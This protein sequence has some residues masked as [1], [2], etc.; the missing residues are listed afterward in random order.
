MAQST[1]YKPAGKNKPFEISLER[2]A[3]V[4]PLQDFPRSEHWRLVTD[5][6]Q[7]NWGITAFIS[8][9]YQGMKAGYD[10]MRDYLNHKSP[11]TVDLIQALQKAAF[12][13][14]ADLQSKIG[15]R[16]GWG[17][18][19]ITK[20]RN[21]EN[22]ISPE[23]LDEL[24]AEAK[25]AHDHQWRLVGVDK[26]RQVAIDSEKEK[27]KRNGL[28]L[29]LG[30]HLAEKAKEQ[31]LQTKDELSQFLTSDKELLFLFAMKIPK[32]E[33]QRLLEK[34]IQQLD[35]E[36]QGLSSD[37]KNEDEKIA[38][39][40][41]FL[42]KLNLNHFFGDGNGRTCM[43]LLNCF[44]IK[45]L[46]CMSIIPTPAHLTAFSTKELVQEI[47]NGMAEFRK[48]SIKEP[49]EFIE[50]FVQKQQDFPEGV[51]GF[52]NEFNAKF[53]KENHIAL[54]QINELFVRIHADKIKAGKNKVNIL[55]ILKD[56]YLDRLIK[57]VEEEKDRKTHK[58]PKLNEEAF[59]A[60]LQYQEISKS[61]SSEIMNELIA[62]YKPG[63][64][65]KLAGS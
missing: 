23:G 50:N 65:N 30:N 32:D 33:A 28:L 61:I 24:V 46:D 43:I 11:L 45:Y 20:T 21:E 22:G 7:Q 6:W 16:L 64:G 38:A 58:K 14:C 5:G 17:Y 25:L 3:Y 18:F 13:P 51:K 10:V 55:E 31:K 36:M 27:E 41:R 15:F 34:D 53:S 1:L 49:R 4:D 37:A 57:F 2:K 40:V 42:R 9:Y 35:K 47:K 63:K 62:V 29:G 48:Y 52:K 19:L 59:L 60:M 56:I 39:I 26:S 54:A 12:G 8:Q 44:L